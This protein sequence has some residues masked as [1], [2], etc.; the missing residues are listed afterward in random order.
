M[1][2]DHNV[3]GASRLLVYL[4]DGGGN[5]GSVPVLRNIPGLVRHEQIPDTR[6][7]SY[8][9][10]PYPHA[11]ANLKKA[12]EGADVKS[13]YV[14]LPLGPSNHVALISVE[15]MTCNS[16]VK[17]IES[18]VSQIEGVEGI[19]VSLRNKQGF[20]QFN[21]QLQTAAQIATAIYDM[22]FDAHV[23]ATF[24][25]CSGRATSPAVLETTPVTAAGSVPERDHL[26][27]IDVDGMVC[28][29]CVQNIETNI[30]K[31][32]GVHTI[33][34]SLSDKNARIQYNP[35]LTSP[36]QLCDAIEEIGF[37]AK[38]QSAT[39]SSN[40]GGTSVAGRKPEQGK[41]KTCCVGIEG[42][43]CHSC[44]SLI[45]STVGEV[46]GV[47][48][49]SVSLP[50]KEAVVDYNDALVTLV[51]IQDSITSVGFTVTRTTGKCRPA[52]C[53]CIASFPGLSISSFWSPAL[54]K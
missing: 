5:G 11:H 12:L 44:V 20:L 40:T 43:T 18:T 26:V 21:P 9:F 7:V 39:G 52:Y 31:M 14:S 13:F 35:S 29:S 10:Q 19:D 37:D 2:K 47:V 4:T 48:G 36:S 3:P 25:H 41:L 8:F 30:R 45:E 28:H 42:M 46:R 17:L 53:V 1:E 54:C 16:C 33:E 22:G 23:T 50:N 38:V 49:V 51:D 24:T 15:G 6:L 27:V 32:E 34:V